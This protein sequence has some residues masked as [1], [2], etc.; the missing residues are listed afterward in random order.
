[1]ASVRS[2]TAS[3]CRRPCAR[4]V[5]HRA[6]RLRA[7]SG[8]QR[9]EYHLCS[10]ADGLDRADDVVDP[11]VAVVGHDRLRGARHRSDRKYA[12]PAILPRLG[13]RL[14]GVQPFLQEAQPGVGLG[15]REQLQLRRHLD[16]LRPR[17][18]DRNCQQQAG[19]DDLELVVPPHV[20]KSRIKWWSIDQS[21]RPQIH[22]IASTRQRFGATYRALYAI[23]AAA[24]PV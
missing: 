15:V 18:A 22:G 20:P 1:M 3:R 5:R 4:A 12:R 13:G 11:L 21:L 10:G 8:R 24:P 6:H 9:V 14:A 19:E 16:L 17:R 2:P 23:P 7:E